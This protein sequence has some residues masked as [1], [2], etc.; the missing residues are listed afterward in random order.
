MKLS[1]S[2]KLSVSVLALVASA[3]S[4]EGDGG[5]AGGAATTAGTS[6]SG[7]PA[8]GST[9]QAGTSSSGG[10]GNAGASGNPAAGQ[11]G[12]AAA[13]GT[14]A[15][16]TAGASGSGGA[17]GTA[18][19]SGSGGAGGAAGG[20]AGASGSGGAGGSGGG[21]GQTKPSMGCETT[22]NQAAG[23]WV[24]SMVMTGGANRPY[25][26]RLPT[27]Y[28]AKRAYPLIVLLHGCGG[29]TN[30]VPME[31]AA[32]ADAIMVRG[33][34]SASGTCWDTSPNGKDV[35]FF[36]AMVAD[37]K[38][39]FCADE[40][41]VFAVGYSSGSWL[42]NQLTC[43]RANVLRGGASVT[44]GESASGNCGGPVARIFIHDTDDNDNKIDGSIRARDR[45]LTQNMCTKPAT[46]MPVD[47]SP[48]ALYQGCKD[49]YPVEWCQTSGKAHGRQDSFAPSTFWN[50]FK[51]L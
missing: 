45:H 7:G 41:R 3:C 25:S 6:S 34:G 40:S 51:K 49:G 13:G 14:A 36:D 35:P 42:V 18:G 4:D 50:F 32:G 17:G 47:P 11:A 19:A 22:T 29:G 26:V 33:T 8:G 31:N 12:A 38:A 44:G 15:A 5:G 20:T 9:A 10:T 30:N 23:M 21:G 46:S 24:Q 28:D 16:G 27:G 39:R 37:A 1:A 48:C 2:L 43:I